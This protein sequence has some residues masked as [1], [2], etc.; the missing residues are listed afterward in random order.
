MLYKWWGNVPAFIFVP[1]VEKALSLTDLEGRLLSW[2]LSFR[3][4]E[5]LQSVFFNQI[6][7]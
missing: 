7:F 6:K 2:T 1:N 3:L 4:A 5:V